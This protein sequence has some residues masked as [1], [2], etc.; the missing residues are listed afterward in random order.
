LMKEYIW[1]NLKDSSQ[2]INNT[3]YYDSRE[4]STASN[5]LRVH[6]GMNL[7]NL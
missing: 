1:N 5:K 3:K 2:E 4:P 6:G 7:I